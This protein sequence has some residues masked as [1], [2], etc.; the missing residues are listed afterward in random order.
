MAG[1][2]NRVEQQKKTGSTL[3]Y[4]EIV[5]LRTAE[6]KEYTIQGVYKYGYRNKEDV[7]NLPPNTMVVG[8]QNVLTN[9]AEQIAIRNGYQL[10]GP[11]GTQSTIIDSNFDLQTASGLVRNLRKWGTTLEVRY[12]NPVTKAVSWIALTGLTGTSS[13]LQILASYVA[14]FCDWFDSKVRPPMLEVVYCN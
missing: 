2:V 11:A 6:E 13:Y 1:Q 9:A 7:S 10:D 12:V 8:S 14:N 4:N 3:T 5:K